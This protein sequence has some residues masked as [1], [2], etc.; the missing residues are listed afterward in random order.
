MEWTDEVISR[1]QSLW[2]Q[3]LSTAEIGRQLSITKN[4][5]VGKAHRLGLPPRPSPI[6]KPGKGE[7]VAS[8]GEAAPAKTAVK[9]TA[10]SVPQAAP[11]ERQAPEPAAQPAAVQDKPVQ[12]VKEAVVKPAAVMDDKSD[13][14]DVVPSAPKP[15]ATVRQPA[16]SKP[17]TA[18]AQKGEP[19]E[20]KAEQEARLIAQSL[21]PVLRSITGESS[22]RRGPSCCWPLGDPGTPGFRFCG[23]KPVPGKPY[24]AEH[25][26]LAYVKLRDR[27][28]NVA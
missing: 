18:A 7:A 1:L 5:V 13:A 24:C 20:S 26:A 25:A 8:E 28:D 19:P 17:R 3:G 2:Q 27:R 14:A 4:A 11:A 21:R 12:P 6:R 23:A 15:S 10:S 22:S 9:A 16:E